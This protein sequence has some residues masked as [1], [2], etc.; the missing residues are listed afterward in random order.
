MSSKRQNVGG[1]D[2]EARKTRK[3]LVWDSAWTLARLYKLTNSENSKV[4][5]K[6]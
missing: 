4:F 1:V 5:N 2:R 3:L 6:H